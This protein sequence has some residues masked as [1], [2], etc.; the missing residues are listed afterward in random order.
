MLKSRNAP[1]SIILNYILYN[2]IR[3]VWRYQ[4]YYQNPCIE[5]DKTTQWPK[6]K[7]QKHK[8]LSTK[9]THKTKGRVT[10]TP[11]NRGWTQVLGRVSS[12]CSTSGTRRVNLVANL[13]KSP[14]WGKDREV[15]T[16][17]EMYPWSFVTQI[18]HSGQP[19][20][21]GDCKTFGVMT[22]T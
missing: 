11:L 20:H 8:Q 12:S 1:S 18:F 6:G 19:S 9:H 2:W 17:S 21:G 3:R 7:V 16:T 4:R 10:R 22:S 13:V 14:E 15:F 5:E